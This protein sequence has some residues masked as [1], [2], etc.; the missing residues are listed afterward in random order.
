VKRT[1]EL[2]GA[3][4]PDYFPRVIDDD[5]WTATR[6]EITRRQRGCAGRI[7]TQVNIFRGLLRNARD[8]G[9]YSVTTRNDDGRRR[10]VLVNFAARDGQTSYATFP[11]A[12][13]EAAVLSSLR[14][15]DPHEILNG[16]QGPDESLVLAGELA[17]TEAELADAAA[18]LLTHGFSATLAEHVRALEGRK[19]DQS[20]RLDAARQ[21]ALHPLSESWG[22]AKT[23]LDLLDAEDVRKTREHASGTLHQEPDQSDVRTRLRSAL[24]RL[25]ES[26][27]VLV[28][29]RG[30]D[31]LAA[32]QVW[33]FKEGGKAR[34]DYLI[35]HRCPRGNALHRTPGHWW[36]R[37]FADTALPGD[38]DLRRQTDAARLA[39][40]LLA[41]DLEGQE[42]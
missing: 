31:R 22:E 32:V 17:R 20:R 35:Y 24:R 27:W 41:V 39:K 8:G 34:R 36:S 12:T 5:T 21:K 13:F 26:I 19:E 4:I 18:N 38:L 7:G 28:V 1:G 14:E 15:L 16:D 29:K 2:D 37:S 30:R 9:S 23:L 42:P 10:Q 25:V 40:A 33:F 6:G 11:L 3:A